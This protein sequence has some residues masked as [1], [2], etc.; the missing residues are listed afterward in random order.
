MSGNWE[1]P[2]G[3]RTLSSSNNIHAT[4]L[5]CT[6]ISKS[7]ERTGYFPSPKASLPIDSRIDVI[8]AWIFGD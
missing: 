7:N 5:C 2:F 4:I 6:K 1:L 8:K 3:E